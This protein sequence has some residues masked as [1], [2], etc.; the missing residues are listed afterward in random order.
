MNKLI[1]VLLLMTTG[2]VSQAQPNA[3]AD[4]SWKKEYRETA[5]RVNDLVHTKLDVKFDYDNS[6]LNGKAW[7]TLKPHF[8]STD[9]L[10]LD[11]KGM[12][13]HK[14][15]MM[16]GTTMEEL[17]YKYDGWFLKINLGKKYKGGEAYTVFIDY[18]AKPNEVEVKGSAAI[19][20]AK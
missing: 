16:K 3:K 17:K 13:I 1:I 2:F 8:Y 12:A 11:A 15:A 4:T 9:S 5:A 20:D 18:T 7:I 6:Y 10:T 19:N 14:V